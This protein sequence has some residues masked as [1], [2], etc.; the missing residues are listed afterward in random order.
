MKVAHSISISLTLLA[1]AGCTLPQLPIATPEPLSV[2]INVKM[3][4]YQHAAEEG[5][6]AVKTDSGE[7]VVEAE[8][9]TAEVR[10]SAEKGIRNRMEQI[11]TLKNNR[12][13]G[14]NRDGLVEV[15][16][17]P[18]GEYGDYTVK[19][20]EEENADRE[21]V[22]RALALEEKKPFT[23]LKREQ[24]ALRRKQSFKGEWVEEEEAD[25]TWRWVQKAA[26]PR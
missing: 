5:G 20:V 23:T 2:N 25:G 14:E 16:E 6:S 19:T 22:M 12:L 17:V 24:G 15:R 18:P 21:T 26:N 8:T 3:D 1:M 10:Q 7:T 11:Q 13:I 4:V 9:V